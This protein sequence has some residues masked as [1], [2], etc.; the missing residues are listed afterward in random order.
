MR[1]RRRRRRG[2]GLEDRLRGRGLLL[3]FGG[4]L[5]ERRLG[6]RATRPDAAHH[7]SAGFVECREQLVRLRGHRPGAAHQGVSELGQLLDALRS[8]L[9]GAAPR[10]LEVGTRPLLGVLANPRGGLL[11]GTQHGL[12]PRPDLPLLRGLLGLLGLL[13]GLLGLAPGLRRRWLLRG[14]LLRR[15][16]RRLL[17]G[18]LLRR[19]LRRLRRRLLL[20]GLLLL[21]RAWLLSRLLQA[22]IGSGSS[23]GFVAASP[24][25]GVRA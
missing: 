20:L 14:R 9:V 12:D 19:L 13:L 6:V 16:R 22:R 1:R 17:R 3:I 10:L 18:L 7:S 8:D 15:L 2:L 5:R 23:P 11:G 4:G 24:D 21:L 25:H